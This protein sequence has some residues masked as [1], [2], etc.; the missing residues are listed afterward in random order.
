M[1]MFIFQSLPEKISHHSFD[2]FN[3]LPYLAVVI[4]VFDGCFQS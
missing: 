4:S 1:T 2:D 3:G